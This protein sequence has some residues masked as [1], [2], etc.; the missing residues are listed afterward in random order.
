M[1]KNTNTLTQNLSGA[2]N[3]RNLVSIHMFSFKTMLN[4]FS[5]IFLL[6]KILSRNIFKEI[7]SSGPI[8]W[9]SKG[10]VRVELDVLKLCLKAYSTL[11]TPPRPPC[12]MFLFYTES[13]VP[14]PSAILIRWSHAMLMPKSTLNRNNGLKLNYKNTVSAFL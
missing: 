3:N 12:R 2:Q 5:F 8:A 1:N 9:P 4:R 10:L 6:S 7:N 14:L 11:Y 13:F